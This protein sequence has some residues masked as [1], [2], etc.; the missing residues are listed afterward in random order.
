MR[1]ASVQINDFESSGFLSL[2]NQINDVLILRVMIEQGKRGDFL[3]TSIISSSL[4]GH[5]IIPSYLH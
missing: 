1:L 3:L 4:K 2:F 5:L